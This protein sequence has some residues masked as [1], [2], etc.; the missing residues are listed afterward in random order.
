MDGQSFSP[1]SDS[2]SHQGRLEDRPCLCFV[3]S[4]ANFVQALGPS[5][6]AC[7]PHLQLPVSFLP[8]SAALP[9]L[10]IF[11]FLSAGYFLPTLFIS[12]YALK[13]AP[14][15]RSL[16]S[17][18]LATINSTAI[19]SRLAFGSLSD[20]RRFTVPLV[21]LSCL[22]SGLSVL[23]IWG[24]AGGTQPGLVGFAAAFGVMSGGFSSLWAGMIRQVG[25]ESPA[26]A[27]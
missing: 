20:D 2:G 14:T 26:Q 23:L 9:P 21:V 1:L 25:V 8:P 18:S 12:L 5:G 4:Q 19:I 11:C 7:L 17:I 15:N 24:I 10:P 16:G 3:G 6:P 27:T 22:G 13:V